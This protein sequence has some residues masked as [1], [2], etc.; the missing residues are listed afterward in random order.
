MAPDAELSDQEWDDLFGEIN[1]RSHQAFAKHVQSW[2]DVALLGAICIYW[3]FPHNDKD[4]L[5][6]MRGRLAQTDHLGMD[7]QSLAHLLRAI[8]EMGGF[9]PGEIPTG[10]RGAQ[11]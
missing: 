3:N 11:P 6:Y 10:D 1:R 5:Q 7:E 8:C 2:E 9:A 4:E